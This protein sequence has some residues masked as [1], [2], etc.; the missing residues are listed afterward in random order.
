MRTELSMNVTPQAAMTNI[1]KNG[2]NF[3]YARFDLFIGNFERRY[4]RDGIDFLNAQKGEHILEIGFGNGSCLPALGDA[5]GKWGKLYGVEL[6][7]SLASSAKRKLR[8]TK[9]DDHSEIHTIDAA[10]LPFGA[11]YLDGIFIAFTLNSVEDEK[12]LAITKQCIRVLR[13]GG[14]ISIVS[15]AIPKNPGVIFRTREWIRTHIRFIVKCRPLDG[16]VLLEKAGFHVAQMK[17]SS[18]YG[19]PVE[20]LLAYKPIS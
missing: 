10:S 3:L 13:P 1:F 14:R 8:Q 15:M 7:K 11:D 4:Y 9:L 18:M 5:V 2:Y 20:V 16:T 12:A 19:L 17:P 6:S